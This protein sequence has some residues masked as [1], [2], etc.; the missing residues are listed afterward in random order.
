MP[1]E[2][3][4]GFN[5]ADAQELVSLIGGNAHVHQLPRGRQLGGGGS[6]S[7]IMVQFD[8]DYYGGEEPES[9]AGRTE[10]DPNATLRARVIMYPCGSSSAHGE[11]ENGY[12]EISDDM[13]WLEGRDPLELSG[14][15]AMATLLT[16][17]DSAG[18]STCRWVL[19]IPNFFR[20]VIN[21]TDV[22]DTGTDIDIYTERQSVYGNCQLPVQKIY[23]TSCGDALEY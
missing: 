6:G 10:L 4:F 20:N 13:G 2:S 7:I 19:M 22:I 11:D 3:T 12:V 14:K 15:T 1:A 8:T 9:C 23:T 21:V 17:A 18:Y 5:R 16:D